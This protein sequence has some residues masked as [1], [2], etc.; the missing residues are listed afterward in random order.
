MHDFPT[1][2]VDRLR[3][4]AADEASFQSQLAA[5]RARLPLSARVNTLKT[6]RDTV[7]GELAAESIVAQPV[8]WCVDA[9]L[10]SGID[11]RGLTQLPLYREGKIYLQSLSSQIPAHILSPG[12]NDHI[13][14]LCAAPGSKTT[15]LSALMK[16]TG[17]IVANDL[18][19]TRQFKLR[20]IA[21]TLG[22]TNI[23][24][25]Q[26]DGRSFWRAHVEEFD[27]VLVDAPCSMEGRMRDPKVSAN[28]SPKQVKRLSNMQKWLLRSAL[29]S[30]RSGGYVLYSTCTIA[31]QECEEV[32]DW[33]L[34]KDGSK[35]KVCDID[36]SLLPPEATLGLTHWDGRDY[37]PS[38]SKT[39]RVPPTD[40]LEAFYVALLR[41]I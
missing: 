26:S 27:A 29:S 41:R 38:L 25:K 32:V 39:R 28:W 19:R 16:N 5:L 9:L 24:T 11:N 33:L 12:S 36:A 13:L 30:T 3:A 21:D 2:F 40:M 35:V 23:I 37:D 31:P 20:A 34:K 1:L 17:S 15:Q 14:D 8:P 7:M 6:D 4:Q 10:L 18:S 22:A